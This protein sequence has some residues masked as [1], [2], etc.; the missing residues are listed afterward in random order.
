[1]AQNQTHPTEAYRK[2]EQDGIPIGQTAPFIC[3]YPNC[4]VYAQHSWGMIQSLIAYTGTG[5]A[6]GRTYA[7]SDKI[8]FAFCTSCRQESIFVNGQL[9]HPLQSAAP[10]PSTDMPADLI[11]DFEEARQILPQSPRGA[12]AL[13]RLVVQKLLPHIGAT[14]AD[15]NSG[16]KELVEGG[17]IN[18]QLQQ[19]LDSVRVVGNEA[20]H[21]GTMDLKDDEVTALALFNLVNFIVQKAITEPN[22]VAA[23]YNSLPKNKLDG[24]NA[25]DG[26]GSAQ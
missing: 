11:I 24:I 25:R 3:P 15:I 20:V 19:A 14:K 10:P 18:A 23:I 17:V 7:G 16:I 21:P 4:R 9:V 2:C 12:A 22:E 6:V 8:A 5:G 26:N 1:M 13:L